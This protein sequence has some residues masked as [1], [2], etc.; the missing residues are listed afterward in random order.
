VTF[1]DD[2]SKMSWIYFMKTKDE[3]FIHFRAFKAQ[4]EN[5]TGRKN[6]TLRIENVG[7]YTST[8]FLDFCK[9]GKDQEGED[10]GLQPSAKWGC[11]EEE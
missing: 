7:E 6:K 4:V 2:F 8:K 5:M 10:S 9:G 1:I 3:V 11:R